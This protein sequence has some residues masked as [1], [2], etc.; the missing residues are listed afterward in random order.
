MTQTN[1]AWNFHNSENAKVNHD[2]DKF[3]KKL[4]KKL[5]EKDGFLKN[6]FL[7]YLDKLTH[8]KIKQLHP[9]KD[10]FVI[11]VMIRNEGSIAGKSLE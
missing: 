9:N 4:L 10:D 1:K 3:C 11:L 6:Y 7:I 8:G 5:Q 2:Y